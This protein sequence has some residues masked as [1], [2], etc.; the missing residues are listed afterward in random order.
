M[1]GQFIEDEQYI[2]R[3]V[4]NALGVME[5][6]TLPLRHWKHYDWLQTSQGW[7]M[8]KWTSEL[9]VDRHSYSGFNITFQGYLEMQLVMDEAHRHRA[10]EKVPLFINPHRPL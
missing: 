1:N 5:T 3:K 8:E 7:N 4:K 2:G 10:G 9:D 6:V